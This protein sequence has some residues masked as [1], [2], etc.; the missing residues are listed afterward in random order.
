MGSD[1]AVISHQILG[2]RL[3]GIRHIPVSRRR[4]PFTFQTA[5]QPLHGRIIPTISPPTHALLYPIS[6]QL[7]AVSTAAVMAALVRVK[8]H[9][10]RSPTSLEGHGQHLGGQFAVRRQTKRVTEYVLG[11]VFRPP[12]PTK[13]GRVILPISLPMRAGFIWQGSKMCLPVK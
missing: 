6:P 8:H 10:C 1:I 7:L 12:S 13:S 3:L 5:K 4:H 9:P 2:Y 11:Q